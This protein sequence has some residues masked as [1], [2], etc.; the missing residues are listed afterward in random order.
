MHNICDV[1][2]IIKTRTTAYHPLGDGQVECQNH[3]LQAMISAIV[4]KHSDDWDLFVD[5]VV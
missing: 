5:P 4:S 1:M 2:G 3:T